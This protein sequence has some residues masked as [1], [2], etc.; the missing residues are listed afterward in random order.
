[1]RIIGYIFGYLTALS[2][3]LLQSIIRLL[4]KTIGINVYKKGKHVPKLTMQKQV[5]ND[6]ES[7]K[8]GELFEQYIRDHVFR[9]E[10]Y[11]VVERTHGFQMNKGDYIE[12]TLKPD[13]TFR[14]NGTG[15]IFYVEAK[16][17]QRLYDN[18]LKWTKP[19]QL[20]R[21]RSYATEKPFY[22]VIGLGG[23]PDNPG[24]LFLERVDKLTNPLIGSNSLNRL[25]LQSQR[26]AYNI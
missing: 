3:F 9:K 7:F 13:F 11:T 12:S 25:F 4:L 16:W 20:K 5:S 2:V 6:E 10:E 19:K 15:K 24:Q 1:M 22:V 26:Q 14:K 23:S 17:R 21:Y 18:Y 8:K